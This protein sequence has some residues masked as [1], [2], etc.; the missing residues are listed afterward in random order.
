MGK[1]IRIGT[2]GSKLAL[3]QSGII[4]EMLIKNSQDIILDTVIVKT[5]GDMDNT[6]PLSSFG[7]RGAFVKTI[8]EELLKG[9][10]DIAVH[11]LK[12]LPSE[13][14][15][16]LFLVA[17]PMREDPRDVL[18][19][20][21]GYDLNNLP[22]GSIIGTGS[23]RRSIQLSRSRPDFRFKPIRGNVETRINKLEGDYGYDAI[24]LAAAGIKRLKIEKSISHFFETDMIIPAPG[25][26]AIGIE[27]RA[28]DLS[29]IK[30]IETIDDIN[31]HLCAGIERN[32]ISRLGLGCHSPVGAFAEFIDEK[33]LFNGFAGEMKTGNIFRK[34]FVSSPD[35][36]NECVE[37]AAYEILLQLK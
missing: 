8:E 18:V 1:N 4:S 37:K 26:G 28:D 32:F 16:G 7:G 27:C 9:T 34:N 5:E 11:S 10:I 14:P 35:C 25:Q 22:Q 29:V 30:I 36:M 23:D 2:R 20:R 19:C 13:L 15:D 21:P 31:L 3:I 17:V 33:I 12:D 24:I 6:S